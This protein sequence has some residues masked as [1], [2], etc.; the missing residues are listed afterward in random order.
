MAGTS[1]TGIVASLLGRHSVCVELEEKFCEWSRRNVERL[2]KSGKERGEI[3][4]IQ[5][6]ARR[7]SELLNLAGFEPAVA[8]TSPPYEM[9]H[10]GG[11]DA[12]EVKHGCVK[13][14]YP[15]R[16]NIANLPL[17][18]VDTVITSPPYAETYTG[19]GDPEKRKKRLIKAGHNPKDF[20]G[21]KA[22]NA[23]LKH[24]GEVDVCL[25]SPPF[26]DSL[27]SEHDE[28][29]ETKKVLRKSG[30]NRGKPISLGKSQVHTVYSQSK[31]NIGNLPLGQVDSIITSPPYSNVATAKE[32]AIS[33]HMQGLISKLSGIP[34]KEFAH[35]VE[36]LKEAVK[37]AQ[38]KIPF[39]YGDSP[40]NIGNLPLGNVDA[41]ITSPPYAIDPKN[42]CH[43]KE[44]KTL[45]DY[46]KKRG[47]KPAAHPRIGYSPNEQNIG[48]LPLGSVD[49]VITSPPYGEAQEGSGI[50]KR[51]YQGSK[52]SPADL[53]GKRSYMPDK[54]ESPENISKLPQG[55]IDA[56]ITSPPYEGSLEGTTRHTRGG[57]ASRDPALA[58]TGSYA[59]V[60]SFGVT[61]GYSPNKDNIGNLKK[62]T[63]LEAMLQVYSEMFRVLKPNGL[64]IVIVKPFIRNKRVVD[65]PWHTW[66]LMAKAGFTLEKLYKLRLKQQSFWRILQ[67]K[68]APDLERICHEYVIVARKPTAT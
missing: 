34:V 40:N 50:A 13:E 63:Y 24:Y 20:L 52:H 61:A 45:Q 35:N 9:Q 46:D 29:K 1:S 6:D 16:N 41:V 47:F 49:T 56:V 59:T 14:R 25:T 2:E 39:K 23:V 5:G 54:F 32:G 58:Q 37:I 7:L 3:R 43:T 48:N 57:I 60:M 53:V 55:D 19:G 17:G 12:P 30:E 44:G 33:P 21:G 26:A 42:V 64:A 22:R 36:K 31:E 15:S 27:T 38:S 67:Y 18:N 28:E 51:G 66:L 10:Q 65:L 68:K 4:I 8:I 62:E 11:P